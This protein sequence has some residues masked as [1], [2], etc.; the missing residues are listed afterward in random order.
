MLRPFA[1]TLIFQG[2]QSAIAEMENFSGQIQEPKPSSS[3]FVENAG[4]A[5]IRLREHTRPLGV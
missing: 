3:E 1:L 4:G 2:F 5:S